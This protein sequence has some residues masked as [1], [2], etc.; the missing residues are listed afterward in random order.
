MCEHGEGGGDGADDPEGADQIFEY[1]LEDDIMYGKEEDGE[2]TGEGKGPG[3]P[4][5]DE[6]LPTQ[7]GAFPQEMHHA[8]KLQKR[9]SRGSAFACTR[10][11]PSQ[12][13]GSC[14]T[15]RFAQGDRVR[16]VRLMPTILA[17]E[18]GTYCCTRLLRKNTPPE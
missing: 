16:A 8:Q 2:R 9:G 7:H 12:I 18:G 15:L 5:G 10:L 4:G 6:A 13:R 14:Q 3:S 1:V 17:H 11:L